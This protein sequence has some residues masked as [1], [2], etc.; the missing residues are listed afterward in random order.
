MMKPHCRKHLH[1]FWVKKKTLLSYSF[2]VVKRDLEIPEGKSLVTYDEAVKYKSEIVNLLTTWS[3][4]ALD[5]GKIDGSGYGN[6]VSDKEPGDE[7]G[8]KLLIK[9][10]YQVQE[11][12][13][14]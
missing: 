4:V 6:N 9:K 13:I 8:D 2:E 1:L 14:K 3:I 11:S 5:K 10:E 12:A 7:C